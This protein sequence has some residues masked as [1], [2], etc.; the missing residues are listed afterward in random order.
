[1]EDLL[2]NPERY[3]ALSQESRAAALRYVE[4]VNAVPFEQLLQSIV[5]Q[6]KHGTSEPAARAVQSRQSLL[7]SLSPEKRRLLA[8][9]LKK[10]SRQPA[11]RR[12]IE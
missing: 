10:K 5:K 4:N 8:L 1:M 3:E 11:N 6:P 9:R 12:I 2:G 7:E